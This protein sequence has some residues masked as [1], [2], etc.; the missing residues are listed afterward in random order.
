[1]IFQSTPSVG[2]ATV[3]LVYKFCFI[4]IISIHAL[5]GEGDFVHDVLCFFVGISIHALRGEG[6]DRENKTIYVFN[7]SIHALRG[8]GDISGMN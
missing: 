2:R 8:E 6:D 3:Y 1:M 5:R 4:R 7:I